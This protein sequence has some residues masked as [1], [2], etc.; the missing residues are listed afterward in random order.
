MSAIQV[1]SIPTHGNFIFNLKS[2]SKKSE[3]RKVYEAWEWSDK[4]A[5]KTF[6]LKTCQHPEL[7]LEERIIPQKA[8][9]YKYN[10]Y[11]YKWKHKD[12]W[13]WYCQQESPEIKFS[14]FV[15]RVVDGKYPKEIAITNWTE[16]EKAKAEKAKTPK[17]RKV[18]WITTP[19]YIEEKPIEIE[20]YFFIKIKYPE[21]VARVFIK[22]YE[23]LIEELEWKAKDI[24]DKESRDKIEQQITK[25]HTE[26]ML[27]KCYNDM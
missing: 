7:P 8:I 9:P 3:L 10:K 23:S 26:L 25:I 21:E 27:F 1:G 4:V 15:A 19:K 17:K 14:Q 22:E 12:L 24:Y 18:Y 20:D 6:Y 13:D 2:M 11:Q 5:F 16:R